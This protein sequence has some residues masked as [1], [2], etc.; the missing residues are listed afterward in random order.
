MSEPS[1]EVDRSE[2]LKS[3]SARFESAWQTALLGGAPPV[4]DSFLDDVPADERQALRSSLTSLD[5]EYRRRVGQ[6]ATVAEQERTDKL[7]PTPRTRPGVEAGQVT[8]D[9]PGSPTVS[10]AANLRVPGYEIEAELGRGGMG[11]VYRACQTELRRPVALKIILAGAH[12]SPAQ[13][14]RFRAEARTEARL[15]HP[16][17]VGVYDI[18]EHDGVPYFSL[19]L[20]EGGSL[21]DKARRQPQPPREAAQLVETLARTVHYAHERGIIHRDLKPAN[22]LLMADGTPKIADFGLAK[23]LNDE[24]GSTRTGSL[25]GTPSYMAPEQ[26]LGRHR[27]VGRATDVYSLGAILYELLVGR[28]PF[29][30]ATVLDTVEQV[31]TEEPVPPTRLQPKLARDLETICLKCLQKDVRRRYQSALELADDLHRFRVGEPIKARPVGSG[32]RLWRWCRRNPRVAG[33]SAAVALLL[34]AV[35]AGALVFAYQIDRKQRETEQARAQAVAATLE[36]EQNAERARA[37]SSRA[38]ASAR[39]ANLRY[40]LALDALNV[41]VGKVQNQ[42]ENT[43]AT[44][45]V[46]TQI[47]QAA[48]EVL[49]KSAQQGD[50][51]GL[52]ERGLASAHMVLGNLL[53]E[54]GKRDEAVKEYDAC[55][56]I[57]TALYRAHPENDKATGNYAMSLCKQGDVQADY[58]GNLP[59]ARN[60]YREALA[61][62]EDLLAHPRPSAELTPPEIKATVA[63]SCQRLAEIA[64]RMGQLAL[65]DAEEMLAKSL[66]LRAEVAQ[67]RRG[68]SDRQELGHVHYLLGDMKWKRHQEAEAVKDYDAALALCTAAVRDE[69]HSLRAKAELFNLCGNVGDKLF[70]KGDTAKALTFYRA[71]LPPSEQLAAVDGRVAPQRILAQNYYRMGTAC[72]R[73]NDPAGA[74]TYYGRCL[75]VHEK[76]HAANPKDD[77]NVIGLMIARARCGQHEQAAVLA[78][79]LERRKPKDAQSLLQSACC[80]ALCVSAVAH[81]KAGPLTDNERAR[82]QRYSDL[83]F[84]ALRAAQ[85]T[86]YKDAD[87]LDVEPDLDP[88]RTESRF[89]LFMS[90][91]R[92]Q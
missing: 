15:Q 74:D 17:I 77:R 92:K 8:T 50:A 35:T 5:K 1:S 79:D 66:K 68:G 70:L 34:V 56:R 67:E 60:L 18:G 30:A 72:L 19:E 78:G 33:L 39:D 21:S 62:Q 59:A 3:I 86:G 48:M 40:N 65:D 63:N 23:C 25:L 38:D 37:E 47:L 57:L 36:A 10:I 28:P 22:V 45:G 54:T 55:Q 32:E 27:S 75:G 89:A 53:W 76:L 11:V 31:R 49:K 7:P 58:R 44:E 71:A 91:L 2:Q 13:L 90:E 64:Q 6:S 81:G 87:N 26:A 20:V 88:I 14:E 4:L 16:N 84:A 46:R 41:V 43:P 82:Q 85:A 9:G 73:L 51:S 83:A 80:Y 12:A 24:G 52:S 42:L 69:P 61:L 29:L